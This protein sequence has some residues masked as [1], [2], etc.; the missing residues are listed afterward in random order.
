[1]ATSLD[2]K[3]GEL[4]L[5]G[6]GSSPAG[7]S[8][9]YLLPFFLRLGEVGRA[10]RAWWASSREGNDTSTREQGPCTVWTPSSDKAGWTGS[11]SLGEDERSSLERK[12]QVWRLVRGKGVT[13]A[14]PYLCS[15]LQKLDP[16]SS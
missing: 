2:E 10:A 5:G 13:R 12:T 7:Q 1:M 16:A 4:S 14:G 6:D 11:H 3:V 8:S 15:F 9:L